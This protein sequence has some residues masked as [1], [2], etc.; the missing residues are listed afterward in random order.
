[1]ALRSQPL[2][3]SPASTSNVRHAAAPYSASQPLNQTFPFHLSYSNLHRKDTKYCLFT[4]VSFQALC[5]S[6]QTSALFSS[7]SSY[8]PFFTF[9]S[10]NDL[11]AFHLLIL[12]TYTG[13][14]SHRDTDPVSI[15]TV[16][17]VVSVV[18]VNCHLSWELVAFR[19]KRHPY[20][21]AT[22]IA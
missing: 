18:D 17:A 6:F 8:L 16:C 3:R 4:P 9:Y 11:V 5:C 19:F 14:H 1:M 20:R 7:S 10:V 12:F 21:W 15:V 2:L 13:G 22:N